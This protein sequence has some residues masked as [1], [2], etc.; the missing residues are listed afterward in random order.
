MLIQI[1]NCARDTGPHQIKIS[2]LFYHFHQ[3]CPAWIFRCLTSW[4]F[5]CSLSPSSIFTR[6]VDGCVGG[7]LKPCLWYSCRFAGLGEFDNF[8]YKK[9]IFPVAET[10]GDQPDTSQRSNCPPQIIHGRSFMEDLFSTGKCCISWH[11]SHPYNQGPKSAG[12]QISH[13]YLN[14]ICDLRSLD[15][16]K[17]VT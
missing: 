5:L 3:R 17:K 1:Y 16:P 10:T 6:P 4:P 2:H 7:W 15:W 12:L 9:L 8:F 13:G 14:Y 11:I